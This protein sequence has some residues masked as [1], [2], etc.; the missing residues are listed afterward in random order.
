MLYAMHE[1]TYYATSPLRAGAK[2]AKEFWGSPLNPASQTPMG[3]RIAAGAD[4]FEGATRRYGKPAWGIDTVRVGQTD[5]RVREN[6]VWESPWV[7]LIQ[8]PFPERWSDARCDA[9]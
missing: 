9:T 3:R 1:A 7:R 6:V 5:V 2:L 4:L 8:I